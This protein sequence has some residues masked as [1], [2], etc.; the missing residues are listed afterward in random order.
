MSL[1]GLE[2]SILLPALVAGLL[3][4]AVHVPLGREVLARG[5]IFMDLAVAQIAGLG[6]VLGQALGWGGGLAVQA[7]AFAAAVF[8]ALLLSVFERRLAAVQEA[9]IGSAFVL[10]ATG[11]LLVVAGDPHAGAVI[12]DLL[13]GQVLWVDW[14]QLG[15]V[16]VLYAT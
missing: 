5:I 16:G 9:V 10:A 13:A 2:A 8:G 6:V 14:G 15:L 12:G 3:V 11:A 1:D 7:A 4:L